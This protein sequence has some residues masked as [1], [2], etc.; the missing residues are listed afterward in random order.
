MKLIVEEVTTYCKMSITVED[1]ERAF[2][3]LGSGGRVGVCILT[4]KTPSGQQA[5]LAK[6]MD[7]YL[8]SRLNTACF[9][10]TSNQVTTTIQVWF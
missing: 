10:G 4:S 1:L 5:I 7:A 8:Y 6:Q 9:L 2:P 3:G